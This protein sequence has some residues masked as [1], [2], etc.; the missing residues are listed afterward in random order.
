MIAETRSHSAITAGTGGRRRSARSALSNALFPPDRWGV[1]E[2]QVVHHPG[3]LKDPQD[4]RGRGMDDEPTPVALETFLGQGEDT[5][6]G[7]VAEL[8]SGEVQV[9][10]TPDERRQVFAKLR[11]S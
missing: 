10:I 11:G 2:V 1:L 7:R 6:A 5:Q 8:K 9:H 3:D 4:G